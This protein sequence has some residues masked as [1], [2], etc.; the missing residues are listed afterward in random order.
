MLMLNPKWRIFHVF[1]DGLEVKIYIE[2]FFFSQYAFLNNQ[3]PPDWLTTRNRVLT[4]GE[5]ATG[6]WG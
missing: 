3:F 4:A 5:M 1:Q 6:Q 2:G